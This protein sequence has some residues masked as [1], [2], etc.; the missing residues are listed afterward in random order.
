MIII[1]KPVWVVRLVVVVVRGAYTMLR[2][3]LG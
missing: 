3:E 2:S 1:I